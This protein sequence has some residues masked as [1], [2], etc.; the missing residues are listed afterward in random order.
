M[1]CEELGDTKFCILV[2]E[3]VDAGGKEKMSIVLRFVDR[4]GFIRERF[5]KIVSVPD[6]TSLTLKSEIVKVLSMFNLHVRNMRGQ[7]YDGAS[8][9][10]G[11][12][13]GL[14]AMFLAECP[15]AYY[16]HCFTHRL[17]LALNGAAKGVHDLCRFFSTL[18]LV[19]NFVDSSAKRK[20]AL[21][22]ARDD[23]IQDLIALNTLQTGTGSNQT[24]T[25]QRPASTRW[26]SHFHSIKSLIELFGSTVTT[27][28]HIM[29]T[30]S[31]PIQG[32]ASGILRA[33][34]TFEFVFCLIMMDKV[35]KVT[36]VLCQALQ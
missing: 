13:N 18:L 36:E 30:A 9:M 32:E 24:C 35:M 5:F 23:E 2:D 10:S 3:A 12:W 1:I 6:T 7:G 26:S 8:N 34:R 27:L 11:I 33:L 28:Y 15:S 20:G 21:K 17:Q 25:L 29:D 14:Q 31:L 4:Q 22:A 19:V 16:V